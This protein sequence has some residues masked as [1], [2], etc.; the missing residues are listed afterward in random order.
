[1]MVHFIAMVGHRFCNANMQDDQRKLFLNSKGQAW[2]QPDIASRAKKIGAHWLGLPNFC[3]H[4]F[5]TFWATAALNSGQVDPSNKDEFSSFLQVSSATLRTSYMSAAG[6]SQAHI[7]GKSVLGFVV[8][9]AC[10]GE[11]TEKG[12][13]PSTKKL[14]ARR[15]EFIAEIRASLLKH[16]GKTR[17][18]FRHLVS[19]RE[20]GQLEE[21]EK[22][23]MWD[24]TFFEDG[25]DRNFKKFVDGHV[26][27]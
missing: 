8:N 21:G 10:L 12:A 6:Y 18:L 13:K 9:S 14:G 24:R 20:A 19:K 22:W 16:A 11:T 23:F 26:R 3:I 27:V 17:L 2:A 4:T 15:M 1:M 5:R 25:D 7:I